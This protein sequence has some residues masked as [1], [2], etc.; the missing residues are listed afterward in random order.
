MLLYR[1]S[2]DTTHDILRR[3][4]QRT[5]QQ[6]RIHVCSRKL[7]YADVC[8]RMWRMPTYAH[9]CS[10][11]LTY[12]V[13]RCGSV[14]AFVLTSCAEDFEMKRAMINI[15]CHLLA[16]D[17]AMSQVLTYA[18]ACSRMLTDAHVCTLLTT[19]YTHTH[20]HTHMYVYIYTHTHI[21]HMYMYIY[22]HTYIHIYLHTYI[23]TYIHTYTHIL[24]RYRHRYRQTHTHTHEK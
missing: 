6:V 4:S 14:K 2:G 10:R 3:R 23:H 12:G 19:P 7:A 17:T 24:C 8:S 20:T 9:V 11:I 13:G 22:V 18:H 21:T 16:D 1:A 5:A 15:I